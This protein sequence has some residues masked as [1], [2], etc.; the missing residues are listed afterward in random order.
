MDLDLD[1]LEDSEKAL[2]KLARNICDQLLH[3]GPVV[4]GGSHLE[5]HGGA[6]DLR[7]NI[8]AAL[9]IAIAELPGGQ[10]TAILMSKARQE[11][12]QNN[13]SVLTDDDLAPGFSSN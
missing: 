4:D 10:F 12:R 2:A 3:S 9:R 11:R 8:L 6:E 13:Q 7:E 1:G 5:F